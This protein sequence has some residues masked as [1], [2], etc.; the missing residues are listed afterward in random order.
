MQLLKHL[1]ERGVKKVSYEQL[2]K[3]MSNMDAQEYSYETFD[4][5]YNA[6]PALKNIVDNYNGQEIVLIKDKEVAAK[7]KGKSDV[8]KMAKRATDLKDLN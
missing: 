5:A 6:D 4:A 3:L 7:A 2:D 8:K 1:D